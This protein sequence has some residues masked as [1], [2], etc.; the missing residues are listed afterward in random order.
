MS[1]FM[2]SLK[3]STLAL[4]V[5]IN[6]LKHNHYNPLLLIL[7]DPQTHSR[8]LPATLRST[9]LLGVSGWTHIYQQRSQISLF[10]FTLWDSIP[11]HESHP[12]LLL[13]CNAGVSRG[14]GCPCL[15]WA[16]E[17]KT[18]SSANTICK[19][20]HNLSLWRQQLMH[21]VKLGEP[22][23]SVKETSWY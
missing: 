15:N 23:A 11:T 10:Q 19:A 14:G 12:T 1:L 18:A 2:L 5:V 16:K 6:Y 17:F 9:T 3:N 22:K 13:A 21:G 20:K 4:T 8:I 7:R